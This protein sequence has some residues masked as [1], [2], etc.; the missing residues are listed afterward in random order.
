VLPPYSAS[1]GQLLIWIRQPLVVGQ[2]QV[3]PVDL[4]SGDL[5]DV[6]L[7]LL[8]V[9]EVPR[10]VEHRRPVPESGLVDDLAA[11]HG[12]RARLRGRHLDRGGQQL[13][14][15]LH[16]V[17]QPFGAGGVQADVVLGHLEAVTG[18]AEL[19]GAVERQRDVAGAERTAVDGHREAGRRAQDPG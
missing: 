9:E 14:Q 12:P 8:H 16:A 18:R 19:R 6:A 2:V 17:E 15:R 1:R 13:A 7:D 11:G 5:V 3:Q 10:D 4:V